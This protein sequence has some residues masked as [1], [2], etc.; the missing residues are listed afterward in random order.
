M[1]AAASRAA[2]PTTV[3]IDGVGRYSPEIEAAVYFCCL[4]ALQNAGKHAGEQAG[5]V[6]TLT[7]DEGFLRFE[8]R[9]DG[10][11]FSTNGSVPSG[12]GFVNMVDRLGAIGGRLDVES[13]PGSGTTIRGEIPLGV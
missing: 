5:I 2:L 6:V 12:H 1:P 4:E 13:A 10:A 8:V 11:G 9:D 7:G 3:D